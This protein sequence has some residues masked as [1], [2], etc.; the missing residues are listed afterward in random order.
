MIFKAKLLRMLSDFKC[1]IFSFG[2]NTINRMISV[3]GLYSRPKNE[4]SLAITDLDN[5]S[6]RYVLPLQNDKKLS[7]SLKDGD[8]LLQDD[9][10][11]YI[12]FDF[13]NGNLNINVVNNLD[14]TT[15]G[16]T[17]F[18]SGGNF[19]VTAPRIDIN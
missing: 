5:H 9:S 15:G 4:N 10:G 14:V 7:V 12:H 2:G 8:V 17:T 18:S 1:E 16:T 3:K 13:N 6:D 11:T 19:K